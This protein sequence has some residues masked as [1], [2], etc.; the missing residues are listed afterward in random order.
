VGPKDM[1]KNKIKK[2]KHY[3]LRFII[4]KTE[5]YE[6]NISLLQNR[7]CETFLQEMLTLPPVLPVTYYLM[8]STYKINTNTSRYSIELSV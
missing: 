2:I 4:K 6:M 1:L 3:R 8:L 5:R 7:N